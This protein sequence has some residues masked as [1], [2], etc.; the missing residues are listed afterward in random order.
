MKVYRGPKSKPFYDDTHE[1]VSTITSKQLEAGVK[2][3]AL[4]RFNVTK[5]GPERQSVCTARFEDADLMPMINGLVAHLAGQQTKLA[6]VRAVVSGK[7]LSDETKIEKITAI[8]R[9]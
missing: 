9:N 3:G 5:D 6:E 1:L 2:S 7:N 8:L 4:I